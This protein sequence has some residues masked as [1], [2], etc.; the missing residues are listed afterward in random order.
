MSLLYGLVVFY[1]LVCLGLT[2]QCLQ[3]RKNIENNFAYS[4]KQVTKTLGANF[5]KTKNEKI[6]L[7][8]NTLLCQQLYEIR[9]SILCFCLIQILFKC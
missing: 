4:K 8:Y 5:S 9:S 2:S 7:Q 6:F 1:Y 3:P